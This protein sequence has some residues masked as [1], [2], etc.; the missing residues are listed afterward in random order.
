MRE[1]GREFEITTIFG[2][3]FVAV[4]WVALGN[5]REWNGV[6]ARIQKLQPSTAATIR[7]TCFPGASRTYSDGGNVSFFVSGNQKEAGLDW[8]G[9]RYLLTRVVDSKQL[10]FRKS[11]GEDIGF[12]IWK[13]GTGFDVWHGDGAFYECF[14]RNQVETPNQR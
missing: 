8:N 11:P 2:V 4:L 3:L 6:F 13:S 14:E 5:R 7:L 10:Q 9:K 1:K 12:D